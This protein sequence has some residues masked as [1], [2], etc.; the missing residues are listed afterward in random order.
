[1]TQLGEAAVK[2]AIH[3]AKSYLLANNL[4]ADNDALAEAILRHVDAKMD[5]AMADVKAAL[6]C[7]MYQVAEAT[8]RATMIQAGIDAAKEVCRQ[9]VVA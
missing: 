1:M 9:E 7:H 8:F 2:A 4:D 6:D 3:G 5:D